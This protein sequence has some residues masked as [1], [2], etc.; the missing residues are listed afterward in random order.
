M[1]EDTEMKR[2][3]DHVRRLLL[4]VEALPTEDSELLSC[5]IAEIDPQTAAYHIRLMIE[6]GLITGTC[7]DANGPPLCRAY[8]LTWTGHELLDRIRRETIW[9]SIKEKARS[10]GI[11]LTIDTLLAIAKT[12]ADALMQ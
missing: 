12:V 7:R 1:R 8:R 4:K 6:A 3:W 2:D 11:D 9:N 10:S 5:E